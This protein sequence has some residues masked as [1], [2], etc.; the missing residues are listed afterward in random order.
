MEKLRQENE[1]IKEQYNQLNNRYTVFRANVAGAVSAKKVATTI[2]NTDAEIVDNIG[3]IGL[4][5][6]T[7]K[8][9]IYNSG[10]FLSG[11]STN[12][13]FVIKSYQLTENDILTYNGFALVIVSAGANNIGYVGIENI[14]VPEGCI[15][16]NA[17]TNDTKLGSGLARTIIIPKQTKVSTLSVSVRGSCNVVVYGLK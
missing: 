9:I 12:V 7:E 16:V 5:G 17:G 3:R 11:G 13:N 1:Q 4:N 15:D 8:V 2:E 6:F 10:A 14:N